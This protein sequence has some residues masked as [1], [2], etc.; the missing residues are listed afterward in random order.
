M[1]KRHYAIAAGIRLMRERGK[2]VTRVDANRSAA[3]LL[4]GVQ[5]GVAILLVNGW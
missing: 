3:A 1:A 4:A 2:I 5:G